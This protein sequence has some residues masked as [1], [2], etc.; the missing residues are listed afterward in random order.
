MLGFKGLDLRPM[1]KRVRGETVKVAAPPKPGSVMKA[2]GREYV[3]MANGEW[4]RRM[5]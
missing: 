4:R 3:V 2:A 5:K 1:R